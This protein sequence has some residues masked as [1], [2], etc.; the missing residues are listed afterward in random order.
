VD[1]HTAAVVA[2]SVGQTGAWVGPLIVGAA[3]GAL[4]YSAAGP[5]AIRDR[6][7]VAGYFASAVSFAELLGWSGWIRSTVATYDWRMLGA[8]VNLVTLGALVVVMAGRPKALA[9][10]LATVMKFAGTES[11]AAAKINQTLL[12]WTVAAALTAPLAGDGEWGA[13]VQWVAEI[14]TG[15]WSAIATAVLTWLGG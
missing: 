9:G 1:I 14:T 2:V 12:G 5:A 3:A 11:K 13:V 10:Q 4:D 7:A 6:L 15:M 8:L